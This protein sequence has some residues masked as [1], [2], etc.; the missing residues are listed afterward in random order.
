MYV[1]FTHKHATQ[2]FDRLKNCL[3]DVKEWLSANKLKLN[4]NKAEFILFGSRT[5]CTDLVNFYQLMCLV[6]SSHLLRRLGT[7]VSGLILIFHSF[8]ISV[9]SV[10]LV[11]LISGI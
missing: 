7:L 11:L 9:I 8:D 6:I 4:P 5:V 10:K 1:H 2:A 3:D